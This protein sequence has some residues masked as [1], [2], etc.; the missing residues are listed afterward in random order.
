MG[1][2]ASASSTKGDL[3]LGTLFLLTQRLAYLDAVDPAAAWA[4]RDRIRIYDFSQRD[5]VSSYNILAR[6]PDAD[7]DF[8]ASNRADLI[9]DLLPGDEQPSMSGAAALQ[10][11][12]R[13][14]S[15]HD[16]PISWFDRVLAEEPLR[17]RCGGNLIMGS[18]FGENG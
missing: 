15:E 13:L 9:L 14:L 6:W 5:P 16:L 4:L 10:K 11:I 7:P 2:R 17:E 1:R 3:H 18:F 12:F 8:F